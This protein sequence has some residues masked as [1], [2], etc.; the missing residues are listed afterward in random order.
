MTVWI[1]GF[2]QNRFKHNTSSKKNLPVCLDLPDSTD[3]K[4]DLQIWFRAAFKKHNIKLISRNDMLLLIDNEIKNT[5]ALYFEQ[6]RPADFDKIK[7]YLAANQ[8]TVA[9]NLVLKFSLD[10]TGNVSN[11]IQWNNRPQ[12]MNLSVIRSNPYKQLMP[13]SSCLSSL[14]QLTQ[15][16][17]DSIVASGEL[18][19][20]N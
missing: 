15:C 19:T 7:V 12:P 4:K 14:Q 3:Y 10:K 17:A 16:I 1:T 13:D 6:G 18:A 2:K 11:A 9:N 5:L 20:E 8:Q